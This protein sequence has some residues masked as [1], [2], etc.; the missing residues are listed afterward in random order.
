MSEACLEIVFWARKIIPREKKKKRNS[1]KA[2]NDG[3]KAEAGSENIPS[4][5]GRGLEECKVFLFNVQQKMVIVMIYSTK[6]EQVMSLAK[7]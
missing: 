4:V 6:K 2:R 1:N 3:I 7:R 5:V